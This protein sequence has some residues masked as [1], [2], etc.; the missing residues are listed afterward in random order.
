MPDFRSAQ[1]LWQGRDSR[2]LASV[3]AMREHRDAFVEFYRGRI[4]ALQSV[5][6]HRGYEVLSSWGRTGLLQRVI[7]QNTDGLHEQAGHPGVIPLHGTIRRLHCESCHAVYPEQRYLEG[8]I[9]CAC[10]GFIRPSV[11]L[12]GEWLDEGAIAAAEQA[13]REAELFIVLGSSLVVSPANELPRLAHSH[14][15]RLVIVNGEPTPLDGLADLVIHGRK[16]GEVLQQAADKLG[17]SNR[18]GKET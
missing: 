7:T 3:E 1:G 6:P 16:I 9:V 17:S 5:T 11:V 14:G 8:D 12:F 4:A 2:A 15:A 18:E 13:A 10:G